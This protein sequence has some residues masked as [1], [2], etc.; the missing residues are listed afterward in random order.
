MMKTEMIRWSLET[1]KLQV[2]L[3]K[4]P[5]EYNNG[6]SQV[7]ENSEECACFAIIHSSDCDDIK[8]RWYLID[9][10]FPLNENELY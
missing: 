8:K 3:P 7:Q 10:S 9:F 1:L 6:K 2:S 5:I 4:S